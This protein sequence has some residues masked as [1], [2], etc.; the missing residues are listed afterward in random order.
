MTV[1][2]HQPNFIFHAQ[3][4]ALGFSVGPWDVSA[5][6]AANQERSRYFR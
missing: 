5:W 4:P 1:G 6:L 3:P 2:D